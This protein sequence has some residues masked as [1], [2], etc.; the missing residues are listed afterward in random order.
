MVSCWNEIWDIM[1]HQKVRIQI[2]SSGY[3]IELNYE[4]EITIENAQNYLIN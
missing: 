4:K 3:A 2:S 1:K